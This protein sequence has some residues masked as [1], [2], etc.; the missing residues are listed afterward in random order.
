MADTK[1]YEIVLNTG[2]GSINENGYSYKYDYLVITDHNATPETIYADAKSAGLPRIG[3]TSPVSTR[4]VT[5][6]SIDRWDENNMGSVPSFHLPVKKT[7]SYTAWKYEVECS[8]SSDSGSGSSSSSSASSVKE[9]KELAKRQ[10]AVNFN[11]SSREY[12]VT[13][14][15]VLNSIDN[16]ESEA[17]IRG[18]IL[19]VN[20][21]PIPKRTEVLKSPVGDTLLTECVERNMIISFTYYITS[22]IDLKHLFSKYLY[23]TNATDITVAGIDI[24]ARQ[25]VIRN[26]SFHNLI[27]DETNEEAYEITVEMEIQVEHNVLGYYVLHTGYR[28]RFIADDMSFP[29]HEL[30]LSPTSE[31]Y[32]ALVEENP[33]A[34]FFDKQRLLGSF[35][36]LSVTLP[37]GTIY[38]LQAGVDYTPITEPKLLDK[39]G[40]LYKGSEGGSYNID[41]PNIGK[42]FVYEV[43]E[44]YWVGLRLPVKAVKMLNQKTSWDIEEE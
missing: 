23:T 19:S 21:Y 4:K 34:V 15:L 29:I 14:N 9:A 18:E 40:L 31:V 12:T 26:L 1:I 11:T 43:R 42:T 2:T 10:L 17:D 6:V 30:Q 24:P 8:K 32:K 7:G 3:D 38:A 20:D 37:N 44:A 5:S 16:P 22:A 33:D 27:D 39:D 41:D 36:G 28:A 35:D 25:G 13:T